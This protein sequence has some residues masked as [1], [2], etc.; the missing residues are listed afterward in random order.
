MEFVSSMEGRY[1]SYSNTITTHDPMLGIFMN[2]SVTVVMYATGHLNACE[3]VQVHVASSPVP[4]STQ[5]RS[6]G[7]GGV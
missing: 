1:Y 6:G 7:G 2:P 5:N 4:L 3:C